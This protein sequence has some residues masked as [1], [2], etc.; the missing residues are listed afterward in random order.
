MADE[1]CGV[2]GAPST[3]S[4]GVVGMELCDSEACLDA[5][6]PPQCGHESVPLLR[7]EVRAGRG[8]LVD[9]D[10]FGY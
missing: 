2:C 5:A 1:H 3:I 10:R 4:D 9:A 8:L 7:G 6:W